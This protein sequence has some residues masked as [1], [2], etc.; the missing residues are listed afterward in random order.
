MQTG[1]M[2]YTKLPEDLFDFI[3]IAEKNDKR[4]NKMYGELMMLYKRVYAPK[5]ESDV[6]GGTRVLV[7][8]NKIQTGNTMDRLREIRSQN[9]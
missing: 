8:Q 2:I 5:A 3:K 1:K 6:G 4:G 7:D 9:N